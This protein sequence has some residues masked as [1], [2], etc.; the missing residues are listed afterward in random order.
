MCGIAGILTSSPSQD[1]LKRQVLRMLEL[2][3]HRG[4]DDMGVWGNAKVAGPYGC[5]APTDDQH[6]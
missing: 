5:R 6:R 3:R 4:P 2:Q 1:D